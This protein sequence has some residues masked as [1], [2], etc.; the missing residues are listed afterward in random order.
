MTALGAPQASNNQSHAASA[1]LG[2]PILQCPLS[3]Q[4]LLLRAV[5]VAARLR[6][7]AAAPYRTHWSGPSAAAEALQDRNISV[8]PLRGMQGNAAQ[9]SSSA[10]F[11]VQ[12]DSSAQPRFCTC[13]GTSSNMQMCVVLMCRQI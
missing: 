5:L 3:V 6:L 8:A 13:P 9:P 2:S 1:Y 4:L 7:A 12:T 10:F 11:F